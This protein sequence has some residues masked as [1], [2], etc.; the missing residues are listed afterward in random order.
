MT[1]GFN[2]KIELPV[3]FSETCAQIWT[4]Q[5]P[6]FGAK[7]TRSAFQDWSRSWGAPQA[8]LTYECAD[9]GY[10]G[11]V[12]VSVDSRISSRNT[13]ILK[14]LQKQVGNCSETC[15]CFYGV[16]NTTN[17]FCGNNISVEFLLKILVLLCCS[18]PKTRRSAD[19]QLDKKYRAKKFAKS[20]GAQFF[21]WVI[22]PNTREDTAVWISVYFVVPYGSAN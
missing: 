16:Q 20:R 3:S 4:S 7:H 1:P 5:K 21:S 14:S 11:L 22:T 6:D 2:G 18:L 15:E 9:E 17:H 10:L 8:T 13:L 19:R 12:W